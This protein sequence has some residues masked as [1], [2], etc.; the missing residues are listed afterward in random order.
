MSDP[1]PPVSGEPTRWETFTDGDG[2][3]GVRPVSPHS[4]DVER[5]ARALKAVRRQQDREA[6]RQV[7]YSDNYFD[8]E[9]EAIAAEYARLT[10]KE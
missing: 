5:L 6:G 7:G 9:A 1:R 10:S 3:V 4:L 2:G 8:P